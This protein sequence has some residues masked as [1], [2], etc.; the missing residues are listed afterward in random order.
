[1][2][3]LFVKSAQHLSERNDYLVHVLKDIQAL[4]MMLQE[5][6]FEKG[7]QRIGAEQELC[8]IDEDGNPALTA[9]GILK[10]MSDPHFTTEIGKFNLEINLDPFELRSD[11][12]RNTER[13]LLDLLGTLGNKASDADSNI[14]LTGILPSLTHL[15]LQEECMAPVERYR[16]LS[17]AMRT[18]RGRDFEIHIIGVDELIA[19]NPSILFEA[20]NTSFQMHLQIEPEEFVAHYNWA[21][22]ISARCWQ[23]APIHLC[24][25]GENYG[26]RH[27]SRFSSKAWTRALTQ[28]I[29]ATGNPGFTLAIAGCI[30]LFLKYLKSI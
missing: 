11:C 19:S 8:L 23:L 20:C 4:D 27:A 30:P 2:G 13:Q 21:Q 3:E 18:M 10:N 17:D 26:R 15:H 14:L 6:M 5:G 22:M 1:M 7:K 12:L 29:C 16:I 9:P 28:G 25:L 24:F